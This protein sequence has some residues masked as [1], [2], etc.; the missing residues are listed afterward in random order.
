[1]SD[2]DDKSVVPIV[3]PRATRSEL[4]P[5]G[6][7]P[8]EVREE[9]IAELK[10]DYPILAD[11]FNLASLRGEHGT[12]ITAVLA[13]LKGAADLIGRIYAVLHVEMCEHPERFRGMGSSPNS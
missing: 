1:M 9:L 3:T 6:R 8:R 10:R 7:D 12:L 2:T 5:D 13:S 11:D 4:V